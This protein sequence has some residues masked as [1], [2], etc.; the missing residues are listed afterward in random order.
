MTRSRPSGFTLIELLV[1]IAIIA[2]LIALLLPAVQA[3]REAARRAQCVNNF[4]QMG[5]AMHN[6]HDVVGTFPIGRM[7]SAYNYAPYND[8]RRTWAFSILPYLEQGNLQNALNFSLPFYFAD[9]T[10]VIRTAIKSFQC[11]SDTP[12]IQEPDTPYPRGK[13]SIVVNWG[14]THFFQDEKSSTINGTRNGGPVTYPGDS[15][16]DPFTGPLGTAS[17]AGAPFKGNLAMG[18]RDFTDGSSNSVLCGEV[19]MGPNTGSPNYDHRGDIF[20]DDYNCAMFMTYTPPNSKIPDAM[21]GDAK[22]EPWCSWRIKNAPPCTGGTPV[23]NAARSR[24]PGGV[25]VL[26]GDGSCKFIKDTVNP[27][28]WQAVGSIA[29]GEVIGSDAY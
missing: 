19:I 10:T 20:N 4:K 7:G 15:S 6:Y 25:N 26:L 23:F 9:N 28:T 5:L 21:A 27:R 18:I 8:N 29:G 13:G 17:F 12:S 3:A 14:N 2:V 16:G 22:G 24:H 1:V 11:P